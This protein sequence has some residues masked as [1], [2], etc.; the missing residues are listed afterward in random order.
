MYKATTAKRVRVGMIAV[1]AGSG[2][3]MAAGESNQ[4]GDTMAGSPMLVDTVE[5][6]A[7][8]DTGLPQAIAG[9]FGFNGKAYY[10]LESSTWELSEQAAVANYGA[11]LVTI[12]DAGENSWIR[13][14]VLDFDG[15]GRNGW[16]GLTDRDVEGDFV[17]MNNESSDYRN[18]AP[19]GEPN[20]GASQNYAAMLDGSL[21]W[22]DLS[23]TWGDQ[24]TPVYGVVEL[25][26][27]ETLAGPFYYDGHTYYLLDQSN[28]H[29]ADAAARLLGGLLVT[30]N[31]AQ[32]ASWVRDNVIQ[33]DGTIRHS[34]TGLTDE[35]FEGVFR[36]DDQSLSSYNAWISDEPNGGAFQNYVAMWRGSTVWFDAEYNWGASVFGV[37]EVA[38]PNPCVADLNGDGV[39]NF[40][41]VSA[42][43]SEF[44][45]GCP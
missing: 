15:N 31:D 6:G 14:S 9:P 3:A 12:N 42:F 22:Y 5:S 36:W 13:N 37:V 11:H 45:S 16:L 1:M 23:D 28:R 29:Q 39:L 43:L 21:Y 19:N 25:D 40:F 38:S 44:A 30:Y 20:G 33:F 24:F 34:W 10:L 41:D 32:E 18:W 7:T 35:S 8:S 27:P 17:W 2:L 4:R 26:I